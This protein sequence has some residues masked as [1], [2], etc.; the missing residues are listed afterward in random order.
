MDLISI[1]IIKPLTVSVQYKYFLTNIRIQ[2][3]NI[4][5][6]AHNQNVFF[7]MGW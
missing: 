4:N 3:F 7:N 2:I 5:C 1:H 6:C